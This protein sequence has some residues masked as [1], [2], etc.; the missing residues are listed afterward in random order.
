MSGGCVG[1]SG[2]LGKLVSAGHSGIIGVK[3]QTWPAGSHTLRWS[4]GD[5]LL[6][7]GHGGDWSRDASGVTCR[8]PWSVG[9]T[10]GRNEQETMDSER[11]DGFRGAMGDRYPKQVWSVGNILG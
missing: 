8:E 7:E 4:V 1:T 2:L 11:H 3:A 9:A 10:L 5:M 6:L